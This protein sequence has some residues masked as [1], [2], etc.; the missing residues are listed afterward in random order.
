MVRGADAR[1]AGADDEDIDVLQRLLGRRRVKQVMTIMT[2][3]KSVVAA[4]VLLA[5]TATAVTAATTRWRI[6]TG[7]LQRVSTSFE[8]AIANGDG[9]TGTLRVS[10]VIPA[11]W[12][13]DSSLSGRSIRF[14][15]H[16]SC[17]HKVTFSA[18]LVQAAGESAV[19]RTERLAPATSRYV[20]AYGTREGAAFR[21][22]RFRGND[23]L[24]GVHVQP[25]SIYRSTGTP[26]GQRV[27]AEIQASAQPDPRIECHS[28]G[29]RTVADAIGNGFAA[30]EAGGFVHTR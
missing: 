21:V 7:K 19:D 29:P 20:E 15:T 22:I 12:R 9:R 6:S 8:I 3:K 30:G 11:N 4:V 1:Q 25:L 13:R 26:T 16:N 10:Y 23:Q 18:R 5:V 17:H 2:M 27:Y 28:G 24:Q 14:D